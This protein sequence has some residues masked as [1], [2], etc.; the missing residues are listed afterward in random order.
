MNVSQIKIWDTTPL[1]GTR[2]DSPK[3][4]SANGSDS[5]WPF[6]VVCDYVDFNFFLLLIYF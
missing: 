2:Q 4:E 3:G 5:S 6:T 1:T